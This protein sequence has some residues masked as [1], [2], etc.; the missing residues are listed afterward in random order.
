MGAST[1]VVFFLFV[2]AVFYRGICERFYIVTSLGSDCPG[3]LTGEPCITLQQYV[4]T[5]SHSANVTLILQPGD[6]DLNSDFIA[7]NA[8]YFLVNSSNAAVVCG[9]LKPKLQ[10][11]SIHNV[12]INGVS[13][14][15]CGDIVLNR[16]TVFSVVKSSFIGCGYGNMNSIQDIQMNN[17]SIIGKN[18]LTLQKVDRLS[19]ESC[20]IREMIKVYHGSSVNITRTK[21]FNIRAGTLRIQFVAS[22]TVNKSTFVNTGA[23]GGGAIY[24]VGN[25]YLVTII[26]SNFSHNLAYDQGG[27]IYISGG[28]LIVAN[29][30][31]EFN[32]ATGS[33]GF[34]GA[35]YVK[36]GS[37]TITQCTFANNLAN[38][39]GGAFF[40]DNCHFISIS[41]SK[42]ISNR[43]I[44]NG[45]GVSAGSGLITISQSVFK[46]NTAQNGGAIRLLSGKLNL[47][48]SYFTNNTASVQGGAIYVS[49]DSIQLNETSFINNT[50]V[51]M[52]GGALYCA[53]NYANVLLFKST[54]LNNSASYCGVMEIDDLYHKVSIIKCMFN[55]N[56]ATG[57][58][59][60]GGVAC[61][62]NASVY[63]SNCTFRR[64]AAKLDAGCLHVEESTITVD[65][66]SFV[67]N[68][69]EFNGGVMHTNMYPTSYTITH[70][71]FAHNEAD[72][73]GGVIYI[74]TKGS[75]IRILN[76]T[77]FGYNHAGKKGGIV[78]IVGSTL[79]INDTSIYNNSAHLGRIISACNSDV[80]LQA[81]DKILISM[82]PNA[83]FCTYYDENPSIGGTLS[84]QPQL[85]YG[86]TTSH[87]LYNHMSHVT[88]GPTV[89]SATVKP[90][91][92]YQGSTHQV[93]NDVTTSYH[94]YG[95][96]TTDP[97]VS[98]VTAKPTK[99]YQNNIRPAIL[100][101]SNETPAVTS[102]LSST[103]NSVY[104]MI[105]ISSFII[106]LCLIVVV[107]KKIRRKND[108]IT[109]KFVNKYVLTGLCIRHRYRPVVDLDNDHIEL[110]SG[111]LLSTRDNVN[112]LSDNDEEL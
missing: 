94:Q 10:F 3:E 17:M 39:D 69:A 102:T 88:T 72:N 73:N 24:S 26:N 95:H 84:S 75:D 79:V 55:D 107:V 86:V 112:L 49:G 70:T 83:S 8:D 109:I 104:I 37:M 28:S 99:G 81:H 92:G 53:G 5:P 2:S 111:H 67:G 77:V 48:V 14:L 15:R 82:D 12:H 78:S 62:R 108:K 20:I 103:T 41:N 9:T 68:T 71:Y 32:R 33:R 36:G 59:I 61:I 25:N 85:L 18:K 80:R 106:L 100:H 11:T 56:A 6:H 60:G 30:T 54:F 65:S 1:S 96:V 76:E 19:F 93:D 63:I 74:G 43:A 31:F 46:N 44:G 110:N 27:A 22:I 97:I 16:L 90:T 38:I 35:V 4:S 50:A 105:A 58:T 29:T 66:S 52:G 89:K 13:F 57:Q 7:E 40:C 98:S 42:F 51:L 23:V 21:V 91:E 47:T 87:H 45:G 64:N 34:G 101:E